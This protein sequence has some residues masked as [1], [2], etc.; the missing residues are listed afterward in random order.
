MDLLV[1]TYGLQRV[2]WIEDENVLPVVSSNALALLPRHDGGS[3][4]TNVE[5][6]A[7]SLRVEC[8]TLEV[9]CYCSVPGCTKQDHLHTAAR[10]SDSST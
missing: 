9:T 6:E 7:S 1:G 4:S 10:A 8:R 5:G 3:P 2:G